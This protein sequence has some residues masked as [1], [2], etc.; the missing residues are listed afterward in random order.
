VTETST[1]SVTLTY[2][3]DPEVM[4]YWNIVGTAQSPSVVVGPQVSCAS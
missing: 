2:T 4:S 1:C 3:K